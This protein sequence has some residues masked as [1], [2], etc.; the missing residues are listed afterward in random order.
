MTKRTHQDYFKRET[1]EVAQFVDSLKDN[2]APGGTF[3]SAAAAD[4]MATAGSQN[5]GIKIPEKLQAVLDECKDDG[6]R[7]RIT[8]AI[9]DGVK[10]YEE[11]HGMAVPADVSEQALH[12]AYATTEDAR[13]KYK[14]VFDSA[15]SNHH[16][17]GSIQPNRAVVSILTTFAEAIPF[18]HYLPA[19]IG[20]NEAKL[21]IV[22]HQA[23]NSFGAYAQNDLL[24]GTHSGGAYV[25]A[26][27]RAHHHSGDC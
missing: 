23:G 18:A 8:R 1:A 12:L 19:D 27:R 25:S 22:S 11:Q 24:D 5:T 14:S 3:D 2:A 15:S 9:L 26:S 16:D 20:S 4:F 10:V 7:D 21:A 6:D 13:R 17:Q